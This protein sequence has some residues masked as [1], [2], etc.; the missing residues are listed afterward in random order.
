[1][2][3]F[4]M[5]KITEFSNQKIIF[6]FRFQRQIFTTASVHWPLMT[7]INPTAEEKTYNKAILYPKKVMNIKKG[8]KR[9]VNSNR[10][11]FSG[12]TDMGIKCANICLFCSK[13]NTQWLFL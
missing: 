12:L 13:N 4:F 3:F 11:M 1:M 10:I 2:N 9:A 8:G 6:S 5:E 7:V